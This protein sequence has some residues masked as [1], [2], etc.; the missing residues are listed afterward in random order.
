VA[1]DEEGLVTLPG[2]VHICLR[3]EMYTRTD[4]YYEL[5]AFI[6]GYD[7]GRGASVGMGNAVRVMTQ[8]GGWLSARCGI[9]EY[10]PWDEVLLLDCEGD[11]HR[12][13]ERITAIFSEF[14]AVAQP[15]RLQELP[16]E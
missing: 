1:G 11:S 5:V 7:M 2:V 3:P 14:M 15:H 8:F 10:K 4:G 13:R 9:T 6:E 12:A 16:H